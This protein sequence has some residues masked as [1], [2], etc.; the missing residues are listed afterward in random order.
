MFI[1]AENAYNTINRKAMLHNIS[2][3]CPII[4]TYISNCYNTPAGL[5]IIEGTEILSKEGTTKGDP[6]AMAAHALGITPLTHHLLEKTSSN[7]LYSKEIAYAQIITVVGAVKDINCYWEHLNSFATF[8]GYYSKALKSH[9][10]VKSQYLETANVVFG[11]TE[12][13]LTSES[14]RHLGAAIGNHPYKEKYV[15]ELV[16]NLNIQLRLL[17]KI[18][19][20]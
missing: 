5:F 13:N 17:S 11:N 18:A 6:T 7:K 12:I 15:N 16:T 2:V 3:I 8:F 1:D 19:E 20:I 9:L 10:I 14:T 4:S